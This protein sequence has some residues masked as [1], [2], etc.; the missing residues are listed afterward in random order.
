[1]FCELKSEYLNEL[2]AISML[3]G[4]RLPTEAEWEYS[5]RAGDTSPRYGLLDEIAWYGDNSKEKIHAVGQKKANAWG[6]YDTLGN[7]L[8]WCWDWYGPYP[9]DTHQVSPTTHNNGT[10]R[11]L[12]GGSYLF[13]GKSVRASQR[14]AG[15]PTLCDIDVGFRPVISESV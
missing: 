1:M 4:F 15:L 7:V 3:P 12:R 14:A 5:C 13:E 2:D 10:Y 9:S 6:L 11:V 8:E